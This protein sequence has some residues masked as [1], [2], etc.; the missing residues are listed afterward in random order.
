MP[1]SL[2]ALVPY[3]LPNLCAV[4][5]PVSYILLHPTCLL[6]CV[7]PC[8]SFFVPYNVFCS[9]SLTCFGCFKP[10]ILICISCLVLLCLMA[11]V[12]LVLE[13][14]EFS[15][16]WAKVNYCDTTLLKKV[17]HY[18]VFGIS[19]TRLQDLLASLL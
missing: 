13:L 8:W 1:R 10:N 12:L 19:D 15:T 18:N 17:R 14:S 3:L 16:V 5:V 7:F 4:M 11:L 9:S 6:L 2:R